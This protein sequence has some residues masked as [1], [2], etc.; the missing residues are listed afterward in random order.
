[1]DREEEQRFFLGLLLGLLLARALR[2]LLSTLFYESLATLR[3]NESAFW[4]LVL[5]APALA[6]FLGRRAQLLAVALAGLAT[7]ALALTR[8]TG[9]YVPL[10]ALASAA[11]L[12]ALARA[13][14]F[15]GAL[16]GLALDGA[17]LVLGHS[18]EPS[19]LLL[20][21]AAAAAAAALAW[22]LPLPTEA[23]PGW[24]GGGALAALLAVELAFLA[25]PYAASRWVGA[26]AWL[27][28]AASGLGLV[29]GA[30][31]LRRAGG[32]L[33][34]VGA[35]A[36]ADVALLRSPLAWLSLGLVQAA[37]GAAGA[38]LA[39]SLATVRGAGAF[40]V[41][42]AGLAFVLLYFRDPLGLREWGG[43]VP[44]LAL[45]AAAP[46]ARAARP[47][48]ARAPAARRRGGAVAAAA[49]LV[50]TAVA[51]ATPA[52]IA[53]PRGDEIVLVSWNVHQA[54]G[55]RGALDP[56]I[57]A[58]VLRS[59][60]PDIVVLQ[61]SDT[62]RLS[63]GGVDIVR[64]LAHELD[65]HAAYGRAG[66]AV[67]SRFPFA[68]EPRPPEEDWTFEAALD[69]RGETLWVHGVHLARGRFPEER[70]R[71][72]EALVSEAPRGP[73]VVAGDLNMCPTTNCR[74]FGNAQPSGNSSEPHPLFGR[75]LTRYEDAWVAAGNHVDD[76]A[77]FTHS[78]LRPV[79]RIDHILVE[80]V[81][82]LEVRVLLDER[83]R[84]ASDH[85]PVLA[86]I[87]LA[88]E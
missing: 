43:V 55:N 40:A 4:I 77:G 64:F 74:G 70:E 65:M 25:S 76:P 6:P 69:V 63:S 73:H 66:P 71:Q 53:Q 24:L 80:E 58:D 13:A 5:L 19:T 31:R 21:L 47:H 86:R 62:A 56:W 16:A 60:Q 50:A 48:P 39:P 41:V 38:R 34:A 26:P 83:T 68:D 15:A 51:A 1:M 28:A 49:L 87:R 9:W 78:A 7:S 45:L 10:A 37:L 72:V 54:F 18:V 36:L 22:R 30:A 75:L 57:Y 14:A 23:R 27:A 8:F 61:E 44:L 59:V 29:V 52:P 46:A 79:R 35:L 42:F 2:A 84:A 3:L 81:E 67:L 82:V 85:L 20:P 12:L 11:G 17:L 88:P 32:W 33:W